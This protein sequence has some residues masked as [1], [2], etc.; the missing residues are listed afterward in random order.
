MS[1]N[2]RDF[3]NAYDWLVVKMEE[4]ISKLNGV[5]YPVWAWHTRDWK[6]KKP[7]L[8]ESGNIDCIILGFMV[9]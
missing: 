6:H 4:R 1:P 7:D 3:K 9:K 2:Y 5:N 8:R